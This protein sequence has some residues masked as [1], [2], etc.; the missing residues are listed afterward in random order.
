M[1]CGFARSGNFVAAGGLDNLCT[2]YHSDITKSEKPIAELQGHDGYI[3]SCK[4]VAD[5]QILTSS[6]DSHC[7]LWDIETGKRVTDFTLHSSDCMRFVI[8]INFT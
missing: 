2:V 1:T 5:N 4:F 8:F 7:F 3:S 6:G